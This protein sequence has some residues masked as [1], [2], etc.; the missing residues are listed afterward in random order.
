MKEPKTWVPD[1]DLIERAL[2]ALVTECIVLTPKGG[3]T[4]VDFSLPLAALIRKAAEPLR[5]RHADDVL[6]IC[7]IC[8]SR[9]H[10]PSCALIAMCRAIVGE[11][12]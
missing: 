12:P 6:Q 3:P 9:A 1:A 5:Y 10:A 11:K 7:H 2:S 8:R 4:G